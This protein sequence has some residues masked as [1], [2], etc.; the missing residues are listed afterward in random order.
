MPIDIHKAA[1]II[2]YD[3]KLLSV[4]ADDKDIFITPGGKL[5][6]P[7]TALEALKRELFEELTI[8]IKTS[9]VEYI[10]TYFSAA[11]TQRDKQLMMETF[12]VKKYSG[13]I[14]P[15]EEI[16]EL[17]WINSRSDLSDMASLIR[18]KIIPHLRQRNLID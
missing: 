11:A 7:E 12:F 2:I 18:H 9:D 8:T 10:D 6:G 1:G 13:T 17:R 15:S 5:E 16:V 14:K 4:R 3:R